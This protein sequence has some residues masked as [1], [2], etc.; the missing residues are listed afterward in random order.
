[1]TGPRHVGFPRERPLVAPVFFDIA[2]YVRMV[3][4]GGRD[5]FH[6]VPVNNRWVA[7]NYGKLR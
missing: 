2:R 6:P 4:L 3:C 7:V 1:M 5:W